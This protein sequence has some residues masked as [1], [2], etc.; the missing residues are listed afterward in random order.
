MKANHVVSSCAT[1]RWEHYLYRSFHFPCCLQSSFT[2]LYYHLLRILPASV[3]NGYKKVKII[4]GLKPK[5]VFIYLLWACPEKTNFIK[6]CSSRFAE[7]IVATLLQRWCNNLFL[8]WCGVCCCKSFLANDLH[9][10][11]SKRVHFS[12]RI[13]FCGYLH[14]GDLIFSTFCLLVSFHD[15]FWWTLRDYLSVWV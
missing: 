8:C 6:N 14:E 15:S 7:D 4:L 12:L 11:L 10:V 1:N 5:M 2:V 3:A 13:F 9:C